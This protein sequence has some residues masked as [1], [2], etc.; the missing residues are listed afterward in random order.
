M[1]AGHLTRGDSRRGADAPIRVQARFE[2][3]PASLKGAFVLRGADGNPHTA[4]F[5]W[6]RVARV[7]SGPAKPIPVEERP[8]DVAPVRDLFVPF[9]VGVSDLEAGWYRLEASVR[10]DGGRAWLFPSRSFAIPWP[11]GDV[12]RGSFPVGKRVEI[13]DSAFVVDRVE[14]AGDS[15]SV[16]WRTEPRTAEGPAEEPAGD[17]I[18]LADGGALERLPL[19]EGSRLFASRVSGE[20]RSVSYPMPRSAR[21]AAVVV[22]LRSGG[23]SEPVAISLV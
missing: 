16:V 7:P 6:G 23:E 9:E 21:S 10:V 14:L 15:A 11:R 4:Q 12:R 1:G 13:G 18:L 5:D 3:F 17:A 19:E 20:R 22:R 2:R 8:F